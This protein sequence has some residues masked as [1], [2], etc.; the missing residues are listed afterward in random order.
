MA[1]NTRK[2]VSHHYLLEECKSKLLW[3]ATLHQPEWPSKRLQI[4]NAGREK[5]TPS[6]TV[7]GNVHWSTTMKNGGMDKVGMVHMY[8]GILPIK[9][10]EIMPFAETWMGLET[11]ILSSVSWNVKNKHPMISLTYGIKKKKKG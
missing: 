2:G 8:N 9:K 6:Y 10:K 1:K 4:I 7:A 3:G 11:I 5:R